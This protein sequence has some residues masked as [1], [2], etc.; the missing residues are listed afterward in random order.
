M[1]DRLGVRTGHRVLEIGTGTGYH[2]ALLSHRLGDTNVYSIDIDPDLFEAVRPALD[3]LGYRPVLRAGDGYEGLP[4]GA[5]YAGIVATC[6][7]DHVPPAWI[8][9]FK[10]GGRIVAP[11]AGPGGRL[12]GLHQD[13]R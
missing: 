3:Q 7:I 8:R 12:D 11:L 6:A 9:Q 1:L 5:P 2:A 10:R 13:R 4:D